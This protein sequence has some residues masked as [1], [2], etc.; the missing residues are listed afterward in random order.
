MAI[1]IRFRPHPPQVLSGNRLHFLQQGEAT[2]LPAGA[3][4][5]SVDAD[6]NFRCGIY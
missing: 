5:L 2:A 1:S 3:E 4:A 6:C